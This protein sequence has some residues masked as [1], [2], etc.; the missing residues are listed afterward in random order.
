MTDD[1][2]RGFNTSPPL[3][4]VLDRQA[5]RAVGT[6]DARSSPVPRELVRLADLQIVGA[7]A[8]FGQALREGPLAVYTIP[9]WAERAQLLDRTRRS[10]PIRSQGWKEPRRASR[11]R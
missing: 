8:V 6:I 7:A 5:K 10:V 1:L 2:F 9:D 3:R 11:F 4:A